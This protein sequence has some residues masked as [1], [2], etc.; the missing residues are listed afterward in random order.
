VFTE[1]RKSALFAMV[2]RMRLGMGPNTA[3]S[4]DSD[5]SPSEDVEVLSSNLVRLHRASASFATVEL[6]ANGIIGFDLP[7]LTN[8]RS[9]R[10]LE[11][12]SDYV[13][14]FIR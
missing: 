10:N 4:M 11:T 3:L 1:P 2:N 8:N 12:V 14:V 7:R 5:C 9:S 6:C 13:S